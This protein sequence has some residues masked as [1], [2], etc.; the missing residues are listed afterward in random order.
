MACWSRPPT[1][2]SPR[3]T[4]EVRRERTARC[5]SPG[6]HAM[7]PARN[8][9]RMVVANTLRSRRHF[10]LSA[11]GIVIGIATFVLFLASTEQV[12]AVLEKIFPLDEVQVVAPRASFLGKD[13][14]KKLDDGI[15]KTILAR[16]D[17]LA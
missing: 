4:E 12:A 3:P 9:V 17:V 6:G 5:P 16:P 13:V 15:V 8:L 7:M 14:S 10:I 11:F 2:R 1:R